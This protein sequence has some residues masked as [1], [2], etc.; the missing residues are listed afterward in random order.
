METTNSKLP[1]YDAKEDYHLQGFYKRKKEMEGRRKGMTER[2]ME[3]KTRRQ[4]KS[5][6]L[7]K[8]GWKELRDRTVEMMEEKCTISKEE[9]DRFMNKMKEKMGEGEKEGKVTL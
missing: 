1:C 4:S 5:L 2:V 9:F 3:F 7:G 6:R 8:T